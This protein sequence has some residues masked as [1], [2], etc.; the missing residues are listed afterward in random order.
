VSA[1]FESGLHGIS[2]DYVPIDLRKRDKYFRRSSLSNSLLLPFMQSWVSTLPALFKIAMP[3]PEDS[4]SNRFKGFSKMRSGW[5]RGRRSGRRDVTRSN[6]KTW[7]WRSIEVCA[8][9]I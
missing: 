5:V 9:R 4:M 6:P 8:R 3:F 1:E 2:S 7:R